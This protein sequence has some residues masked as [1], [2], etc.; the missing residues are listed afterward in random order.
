MGLHGLL[1]SVLPGAFYCKL[2]EHPHDLSYYDL[3]AWVAGPWFCRG[4]FYTDAPP[5]D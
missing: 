5:G 4:L 2:A 3:V 1:P